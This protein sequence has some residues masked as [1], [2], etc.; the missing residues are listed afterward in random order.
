MAEAV[1]TSV[2][3]CVDRLVA[4]A[5]ATAS[6]S[7]NAWPCVLSDADRSAS[8][9]SCSVWTTDWYSVSSRLGRPT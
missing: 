3:V 5:S 8:R 6:S 2:Y 4:L 1:G 9:R 7:D